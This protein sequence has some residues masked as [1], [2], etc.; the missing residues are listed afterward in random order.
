[1]GFIL[2]VALLAFLG[3]GLAP[4]SCP[5]S[6]SGQVDSAFPQTRSELGGRPAPRSDSHS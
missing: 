2:V 6:L 4:P 3:W 5:S 1:M